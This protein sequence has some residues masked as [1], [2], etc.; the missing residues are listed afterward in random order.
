MVVETSACK[1][2]ANDKIGF[3]NTIQTPISRSASYLKV[4]LLS[5]SGNGILIR[6]TVILEGWFPA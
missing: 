3:N 6:T 5:L 4:G 1:Q 2:L